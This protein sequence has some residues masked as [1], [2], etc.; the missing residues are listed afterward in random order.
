MPD[1]GLLRECKRL[2][3]ALDELK[4]EL[5]SL[6]ERV[7]SAEKPKPAEKPKGKRDPVLDGEE[8]EDGEG[9]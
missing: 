9:D 1:T 5:D 6:R 7:E 8:S 2:A 4:D 3:R